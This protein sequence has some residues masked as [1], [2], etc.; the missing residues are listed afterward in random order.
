MRQ[1]VASAL[2]RDLMAG[3]LNGLGRWVEGRLVAEPDSTRTLVPAERYLE[4]DHLR[5]AIAAADGTGREGIDVRIA[6]SRFTR[7]YASALSAVALTG[8]A[9]GVGIDVS[10][11]RC[12]MIL[13][14]N[15]P[16][17]VLV[18]VVDQEVVRCA[19]RP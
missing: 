3:Q 14:Y 17:F 15:V 4:H 18:D 13:D 6:A 2:W 16:M 12:T 8:L 10:L 1:G 7:H 9:R 19:E 5:R 11:A